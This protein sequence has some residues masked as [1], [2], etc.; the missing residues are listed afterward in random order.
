MAPTLRGTAIGAAVVDGA[1]RAAV[2]AGVAVAEGV[3]VLELGVAGLVLAVLGV[4]S[5]LIRRGNQTITNSKHTDKPS[6][7]SINGVLDLAVR[8]GLW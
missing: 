6:T 1:D 3:F 7:A 5:L 4:C 2:V 8:A